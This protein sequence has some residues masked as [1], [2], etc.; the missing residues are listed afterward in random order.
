M[1]ATDRPFLRVTAHPDAAR[2][3]RRGTRDGVCELSQRHG[4]EEPPTRP[5]AYGPIVV[6]DAGR[7][8]EWRQ[9]YEETGSA[10]SALVW[11]T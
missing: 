3:R 10:T 4:R 1:T 11:A 9:P 5:A 6:G 2:G 8:S 7:Q